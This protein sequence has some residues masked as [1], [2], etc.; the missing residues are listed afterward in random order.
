VGVEVQHEAD[1]EVAKRAR[2][3]RERLGRQRMEAFKV[4]RI[5]HCLIA[6][7]TSVQGGIFDKF[8]HEKLTL[9]V[10]TQKRQRGGD[11]RRV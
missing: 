8:R 5:A 11:I 4:Q 3:A 7:F 1:D 10:T 9:R 6:V 2:D